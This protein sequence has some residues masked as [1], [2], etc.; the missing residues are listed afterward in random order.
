MAI[1]EIERVSYRYSNGTLALDGTSLA[2]EAGECVAISGENGAGKT[3]LLKSIMG[4]LKPSQGRICL[5]GEDIARSS[6]ARLARKLGFVFQNPRN[7]IFLS[8]V[9]AEVSFGPR[10]LGMSSG[11]N[12]QPGK[13]GFRC[14][15]IGR[16]GGHTPV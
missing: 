2:I 4:L 10:R 8:S 16:P 1:L 14:H 13:T 3:T 12:R 6:T 7:Q 15:R 5:Y 9:S 11:G